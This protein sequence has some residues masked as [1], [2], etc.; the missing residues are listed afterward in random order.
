M[1]SRDKVRCRIRKMFLVARVECELKM[2]S[3][4][5]AYTGP[6]YSEERGWGSIRGN[7]YGE[8]KLIKYGGGHM[9]HGR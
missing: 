2:R 7:G 1:L 4:R 5:G 9:G 6:S 3:L 8:D